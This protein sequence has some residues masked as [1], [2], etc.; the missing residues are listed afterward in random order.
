VHHRGDSFVEVGGEEI[1]AGDGSVARLIGGLVVGDEAAVRRLWELYFRRLVG[2]ARR[3]LRGVPRRLHDEE[4]VAVSAFA[5]F[6]RA[7]EL[8]RYPQ[9]PDH[10]GLWRLLA[11]I[12]VRKVAHVVRD[13]GRR[14]TRPFDVEELLSRE[15]SPDLAAEALEEH[16]RLL[17]SLGDPELASVARLRMEGCTVREISDHLRYAP[18]TIKRKLALIRSTWKG[19]LLAQGCGRG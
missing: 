14:P 7:A 6:C 3:R 4:D 15:P 19:E 1:V 17:G 11:V 9:L 2:L 18:R 8:G 10:E 5:S 13:E 12:T 16:R